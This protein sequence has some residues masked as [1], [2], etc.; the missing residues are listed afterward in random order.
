MLILLLSHQGYWL[1]GQDQTVTVRWVVKE[2]MPAANLVWEL[3]LGAV[4]LDGGAVAM[5]A[6][7]PAT[8]TIKLR[9]VRVRTKLRWS[10]QLVQRD[11][12]KVLESGEMA[13]FQFPSNLTEN[14]PSRLQ[15]RAFEGLEAKNLVVWDDA[16]GLPKILEKAK[17]PF[18]RASN[19]SK[20]LDRPDMILVGAD[21]IDDSV[22]SQGP[23]LGFAHAGASVAVFEQRRPERL[24]KY[25]LARREL[26]A[27]IGFKTGHPLF[28]G[29]LPEDLQSWV[30]GAAAE[31]RAVQLPPDEAALELAWW[32]PEVPV[33]R[34]RPIDALIVTKTT[35]DGRIVLCQLPLGPWG[36]D[37]RSQVFLGNLLSYLATRPQ[38][39]PG[40]SQRHQEPP[41]TPR[42]IPTILIPN[43]A[44]P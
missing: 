18:T 13:V 1:S 29:L 17:V 3:G 4:K 7:L 16:D 21:Q 6:D 23:L 42:M 39:T 2:R 43:G 11:G 40:P 20:V 37:P 10:Y 12:K 5:N 32:P 26:P 30:A 31:V 25:A 22:F 19:L 8:V 15:K 24:V 14:W 27:A 33:D 28:D 38:P 44:N 34:P 36:E 35:G 41:P 9:D